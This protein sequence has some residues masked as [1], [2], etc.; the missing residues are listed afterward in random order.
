MAG[1]GVA[2]TSVVA[3]K[4]LTV[5]PAPRVRFIVLVKLKGELKEA[6]N[7]LVV[8]LKFPLDVITGVKVS[9]STPS[10]P[11]KLS[12]LSLLVK[13][14]MLDPTVPEMAISNKRL[15]PVGAVKPGSVAVTVKVAFVVPVFVAVVKLNSRNAK[16]AVPGKLSHALSPVVTM[17]AFAPDAATSAPQTK[18]MTDTIARTVIVAP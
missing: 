10:V 12:R 9:M 11:V 2:I 4:L 1:S 3:V 15:L 7:R 8:S 17:L 13:G 18:A 5:A 14:G 16:L 6:I